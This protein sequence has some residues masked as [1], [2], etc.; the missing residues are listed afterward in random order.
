MGFIDYSEGKK[1]TVMYYNGT[2]WDVVG[3][4]GIS[5][6][7]ANGMSLKIDSKDNLYLLYSDVSQSNKASV[8]KFNGSSWAPLGPAG[9][10]STTGPVSNDDLAMTIDTSDI[11]Y[12][13]FYGEVMRFINGNWENVGSRI[14]SANNFSMTV[15]KDNKPHIAFRDNSGTSNI[16]VMVYR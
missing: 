7:Q 16:S 11:P 1:A 9:F 3:S 5:T 10:T 4:K 15:D 2:S 14:N 6:G 13:V 12:I 8:L